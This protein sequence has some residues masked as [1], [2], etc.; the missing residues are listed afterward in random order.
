MADTGLFNDEI[1][2]QGDTQYGEFAED[3]VKSED[4]GESF[5]ELKEGEIDETFD[6]LSEEELE[7]LRAKKTTAI[8]EEVKEDDINFANS[9][10]QIAEEEYRRQEIDAQVQPLVEEKIGATIAARDS[11]L[12]R[13]MAE[14]L[15]QVNDSRTKSLEAQLME[16]RARYE[17]AEQR[18]LE[19]QLKREEREKQRELDLK[20]REKRKTIGKIVKF[21]L[22]VVFIIFLLLIL[23]NPQVKQRL[24]II[25][26]SGTSF[27]TDVISG[28]ETDSNALLKDMG[29]QL[30]E[31]NTKYITVEEDGT[32]VE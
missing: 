24:N 3:I 18:R 7:E 23:R 21:G 13:E 2:F 25:T 1:R 28:N 14:L 20:K 15:I 10:M 19:A 32:V 11:R 17:E 29:S 4:I 8:V 9:N 31:I 22:T 30:N 26:K 27:M 6:A 12:K 5:D 16:D